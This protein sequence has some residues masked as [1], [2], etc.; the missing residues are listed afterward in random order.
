ML[1][2]WVVLCTVC[3]VSSP[4]PARAELEW[5]NEALVAVGTSGSA[6]VV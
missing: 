4:T 3:L 2:W 1:R 6:L 5:T